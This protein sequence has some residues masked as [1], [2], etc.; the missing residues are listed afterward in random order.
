MTNVLDHIKEITINDGAR[1]GRRDATTTPRIIMPANGRR[2]GFIISNFSATIPVSIGLGN[3]AN[4]SLDDTLGFVLQDQA[5]DNF[6]GA[7]LDCRNTNYKGE[8]WAVTGSS[9]AQ[10]RFIEF[11]E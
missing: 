4:A 7:T 9:T 3:L 11:L 8:I 2:T 5:E 6:M 1:M 10:V